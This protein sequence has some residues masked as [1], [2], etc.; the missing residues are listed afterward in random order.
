MPLS[1]NSRFS[2]LP[3]AASANPSNLPCAASIWAEHMKPP[4][5]ERARAPPTLMRRTPNAAMSA[6]VSGLVEPTS[7]LKENA[8]CHG[9]RS[10]LLRPPMR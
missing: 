2:A 1:L 6:T 4:H 9:N 3:E 5:A 7:R 10:N 8:Y